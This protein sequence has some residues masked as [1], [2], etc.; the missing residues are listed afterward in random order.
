M[1]NPTPKPKESRALP[2]FEVLCH[3]K[4]LLE[5]GLTLAG[6][7]QAAAS[8]PWPAEDG[9][10]YSYRTIE[11]P[12]DSASSSMGRSKVKPGRANVVA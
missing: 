7:V 6:C 8:R 12:R 2:R 10:Y 5:E 4:T 3:I 1:N 9:R 11:H